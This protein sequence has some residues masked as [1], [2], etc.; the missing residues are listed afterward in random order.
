MNP[1]AYSEDWKLLAEEVMLK[2]Y[3]L[4]DGSGRQMAVRY[5]VCDSGGKEGVTSNAYDFVR[6]LR[7]GTPE[8]ED[9][10]LPEQDDNDEGDYQWA[11]E[12]AGRFL[13][14]KGASTM[15]APRISISYPD[16]QRK[17]RMAGAR[18]EVPVMLINTNS[19]KDMVDNRL[20]RNEPGGRF[21]F[22]HWLDT[23]FYIELTVEVKDAK[24][25][26]INPK[27]YRNESWDLLAYCL[28]TT[29]T[30]MI[31]LDHMNMAD[32]PSWAAEW[33]HNDLVFNPATSAKPFEAI[34][35]DDGLAALAKLAE[36]LG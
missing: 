5:T 28:A 21:C 33:D 22:A 4:G 14:L 17:D 3:P 8:G 36:S 24:K 1:G 9:D 11:P 23:N 16:S 2:T 31:A 34:K 20:D 18:G 7:R 12:L 15:N 29:L 10:D 13:L 25:G 35:A 19:L 32:P 27:R 26:W 6:W 30:P